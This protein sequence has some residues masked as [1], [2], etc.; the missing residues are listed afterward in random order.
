V[1][2]TNTTGVTVI[3]NNQGKDVIGTTMA[4]RTHSAASRNIGGTVGNDYIVGNSQDNYL[5]GG[6]GGADLLSG[7]DGNDRLIGGGF[8]RREH[9]DHHQAPVHRQSGHGHR[10]QS[11]G[12]QRL[13]P[14]RRLQ[15]NQLNHDPARDHQ[16]HGGRRRARILPSG[17]HRGTTATF[18]I[19]NSSIDT[20]IELVN[21]SGTVLANN[22]DGAS[23][24]PGSS[25]A[26]NSFLSYTFATRAPIISASA[27]GRRIRTRWR[28]PWRGNNLPAAHLAEL[29]H[30]QHRALL[31][32]QHQQ[33]HA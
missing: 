5:T 10:A 20:W 17:C 1:N 26:Q 32:Y 7:G 3:L 28:R 23:V 22:D 29:G 24:D 8:T 16:R 19:D 13:H 11:G 33:R 30:G 27:G 21:S 12:Q 9:H 2:F 25:V 15:H 31:G 4:R 18:D 6:S 14:G